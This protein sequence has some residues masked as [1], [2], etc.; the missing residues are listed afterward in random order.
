MAL[1]KVMV[2]GNL[3]QTPELKYTPAGQAV[4]NFSVA[5]N[6][7]WT[8][9]QGQK[10]E[11]TE[12]I[13]VVVWGKVAE[14]CA[15]FLTKGRPVF[16]EG[17]MQTRIWDDKDGKKQYT[18]EVQALNVQFLGS[19]DGGGSRAPEPSDKDAPPHAGVAA[20]APTQAP[21]FSNEDIPF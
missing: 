6:E 12:W 7:N 16:V 17:K 14:N 20:P 3:G 2:I 19:K 21:S 15:K 1:N 4:T 8:D 5:V 11:R 10:Q 13:R 18:T 9:K